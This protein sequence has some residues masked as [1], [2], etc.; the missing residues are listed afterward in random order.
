MTRSPAHLSFLPP[1]DWLEVNVPKGRSCLITDDGSKTVQAI[2]Q[3]LSEAN[4]KVVALQFPTLP[5]SDSLPDG[6]EISAVAQT[7]DE[8]LGSLIDA[9][10]QKN[11][12]PA[13]FIHFHPKPEANSNPSLVPPEVE[14]NSLRQVFFMAKHLKPYLTQPPTG[15][16]YSRCAF[17]TVARLNG[18]FGLPVDSG[19]AA[20]SA[21]DFSPVA[22]GLFGLV[23][24]LR[25][26]W[27]SVFCRAVD[28]HPNSESVERVLAELH[29]PETEI[30]EVAYGTDAKGI[31]RRSTLAA[32]EAS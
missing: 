18:A 6:V 32:G 7:G 17:M 24:T 29:D 12:P 5:H 4:W 14:T 2:I 15:N 30:A 3:K 27:P 22:G 10:A 11:G 21:A 26:E 25:A 19:N 9:I 20:E 23:K 28:L 13:L 8:Y 31:Q 16:D 1:P